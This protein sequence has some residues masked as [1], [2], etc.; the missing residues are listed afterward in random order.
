M[1]NF[2]SFPN[3]KGTRSMKWDLVKNVFGSED[4]QPMWVADMDLEIADPIKK[5]LTERIEHGIFGYTVTDE[6]LNKT[7]QQWLV[8]QHDWDIDP[9]WLLYSP[10]VIPTIHMTILTQTDPGDKILIQTPVYHPFQQIIKSHQRELVTNP[11]IYQNGRY[12]IDFVDLEEKFKQ[13]VKVMLFCSPHNPVGRVWTEEELNKILA[14]AE[15]YDVLI[16]SDEIH[17]DLIYEPFK[18]IPAGSLDSAISEQII[19][20]FSPTK[21]FN[22][23]GLQVS[24]AV[25]PD[26]KLRTEISAALSKY[27]INSLNTLG[28]TALEAAYQ[29][30]D[31]W[32]AGLIQLLKQNY[33]LIETTFADCDKIDV[34][35]PEGTYLIWL[36]CRKMNLTQGELV[37]FM[38]EEAKVGLNNGVTFG[39]EGRGFMRLNIASPTAY[40]K[41]GVDKI[42]AALNR[43]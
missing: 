8:K 5:A 14:L 9:D 30:G 13:G 37:K 15:K 26:K 42:I 12:T 23:A 43:T 10:G 16:I 41:E 29:F 21:T 31:E 1:N 18:H 4:I 11:L 7:V 17:A 35:Q 27:G 3:R 32:L 34:I 2:E 24:Y 36:D 33:Q 20:C 6:Q 38:T 22:L 39:E 28:I 40:V 25:I 19:S